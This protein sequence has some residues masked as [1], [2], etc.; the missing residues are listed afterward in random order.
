MA[1]DL[2]SAIDAWQ[3]AVADAQAAEKLLNQTWLDYL[4]R[5]GP[6]ATDGLVKEV[7]RFRGRAEARLMFAL[8]LA[9]SGPQARPSMALAF[10]QSESVARVS[11]REQA[12]SATAG[13]IT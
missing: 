9:N 1:I 4:Q 5:R 11:V 3:E 8:A 10:T 6:A 12:L 2:G 13:S 7:A